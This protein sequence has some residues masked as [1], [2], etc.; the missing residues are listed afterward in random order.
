MIDYLKDLT[1]CCFFSHSLQALS[2]CL[3][4]ELVLTQ[5]RIKQ[6]SIQNLI[7]LFEYFAF[8]SYRHLLIQHYCFK[9][10]N[11][12]LFWCLFMNCLFESWLLFWLYT[13]CQYAATRSLTPSKF[14]QLIR[15]LEFSLGR[16][17]LSNIAVSHCS[18][19]LVLSC[20]LQLVSFTCP[21]FLFV[22]CSL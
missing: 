13:P 12:L 17:I 18:N 6:T 20:V 14:F 16:S 4:K 5:P 19:T 10:S 1:R 9:T 15:T 21:C 11:E 3:Y 7:D 22:F 8:L 2:F